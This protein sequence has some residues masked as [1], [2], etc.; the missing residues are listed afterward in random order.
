LKKDRTKLDDKWKSLLKV[1]QQK[2]PNL[3]DPV[4]PYIDT[5]IV[6][7]HNGLDNGN[8]IVM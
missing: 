7:E 2:N 1:A 4:I 3:K 8:V 6:G 5:H